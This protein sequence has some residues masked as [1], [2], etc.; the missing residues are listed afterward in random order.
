MDRTFLKSAI[1]EKSLYSKLHV[2]VPKSNKQVAS[3]ASNLYLSGYVGSIMDWIFL[4][5][6]ICEKCL[7]FKL[8]VQL[9]C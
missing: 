7:F 5:S 2:F 9:I 3:E 4:N 8:R 6:A 1:C